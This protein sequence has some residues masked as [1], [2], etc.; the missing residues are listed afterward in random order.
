MIIAEISVHRDGEGHHWA[1]PPSKPM[2]DRDGRVMRDRD[3]KTRWQPLITFSNKNARDQ[4]SAAVVQ[5][6]HDHAPQALA[7]RVPEHAG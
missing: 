6:V 7:E 2:I 1:S 4:W 3:G 5:A